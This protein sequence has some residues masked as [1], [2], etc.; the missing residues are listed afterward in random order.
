LRGEKKY[1]N[2]SDQCH[3]S[4]APHL[5]QKPMEITA[6]DAVLRFV[7][8][9]NQP[10]SVVNHLSFQGLYSSMSS[11]TPFNER[12]TLSRYT[13]QRFNEIRRDQAQ[14]LRDTCTSIAISFDGWGSKN[15]KHVIGAMG[16]W[17]TPEW[18]RLSLNV[19]FAE[20]V[21][22]SLEELWQT[23]STR[24]LERTLRRKR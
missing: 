2:R 6:K 19:E 18:N 23:C 17:I 22:R 16:Y 24:H 1:N 15:H 9:T 11:T 3:R 8:Q 10:F 12:T 4:L 20:A 5:T 7:A 21:L 14:L 13:T